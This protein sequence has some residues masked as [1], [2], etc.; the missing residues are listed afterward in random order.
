MRLPG[1][2]W[3][4]KRGGTWAGEGAGAGKRWDKKSGEE[5]EEI[6][7]T[8]PSFCAECLWPVALDD[9]LRRLYGFGYRSI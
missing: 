8:K 2:T 4:G 9:G 5:K 1:G 3:A 6:H 7:I